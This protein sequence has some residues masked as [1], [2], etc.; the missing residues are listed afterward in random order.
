MG[1]YTDNELLE[2]ILEQ[3]I[4]TKNRIASIE[5]KVLFFFWITLIGIIVS[6]VSFAVS[7]K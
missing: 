1:Q 2:K 3:Q 4:F 5:K 6:I 7:L